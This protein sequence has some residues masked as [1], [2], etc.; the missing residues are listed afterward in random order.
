MV[1]RS[2]S[3]RLSFELLLLSKM[4]ESFS[5]TVL[6]E[7]SMS[8]EEAARHADACGLTIPDALLEPPSTFVRLLG[9]PAKVGALSAGA[10]PELLGS[11]AQFFHLDLWPHLNWAVS[12]EPSGEVKFGAIFLN[13]T[14]IHLEDLDPSLIR[15][16]LWTLSTLRKAADSH[17]LKDGWDER[18]V[19]EFRFGDRK[20]LGT[21]TFDLLNEWRRA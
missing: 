1:I 20:Y 9:A 8:R 12:D 5:A 17:A 21:F 13:Q 16:G 6:A 15:V 3:P 19:V 10:P 11:P 2:A 18:V 14:E 4:P 7:L